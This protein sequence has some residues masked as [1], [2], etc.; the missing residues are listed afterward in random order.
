MLRYAEVSALLRDRRFR[1]GNA[2]WP[3]QNGIHSGMF[4]DWWQETLL[5]LEGDDHARIRR[6]LVPAFKNRVIA[7]MRPTFQAIANE[8]I[9]GFAPRGRVEFVHEFAEPYAAR[10]ICLLLGLPQDHW[11]QVA[12]WADDLG[13][14]FSSTSATRCPRSR[15]RW[16]GWRTT[17]TRS[18]PTGVPTRVTTW[19][20]RWWVPRGRGRLTGRELSVA[21]VFLAFAGMETTRNQLGLALQTLLR[22]PDQWAC[23]PSGPSSARTRSRR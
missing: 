5:S 3:A 6:L 12:R 22:H 8:L 14:S 19:S 1:Q 2:R 20:R 18:W 4:S 15:Q 13:A 17:S 21:L 7:E 10:I 11:P 9:D 16:P 23:S